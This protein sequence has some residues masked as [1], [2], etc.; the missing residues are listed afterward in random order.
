MIERRI[1]TEVADLLVLFGWLLLVIQRRR[2]HHRRV[3]E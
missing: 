1:P 3:E 2:P